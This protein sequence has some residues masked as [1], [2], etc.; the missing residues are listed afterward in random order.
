MMEMTETSARQDWID[1]I[2]VML[3]LIPGVL[4]FGMIAGVAASEAGLDA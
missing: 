3:P 1:G 2:S 4:P